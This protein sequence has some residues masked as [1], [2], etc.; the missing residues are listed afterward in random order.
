[1]QK[2]TIAIIDDSPVMSRF[3]AIFLEKKYE[4]VTFSDSTEALQA[5]IFSS[6]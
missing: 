2:L 5:I 3:L 4:V 6:P 1:M